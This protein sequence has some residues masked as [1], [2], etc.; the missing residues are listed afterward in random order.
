MRLLSPCFPRR[1]VLDATPQLDAR[2][3]QPLQCSL[4]RLHADDVQQQIGREVA[5]RD[6]HVLRQLVHHHHAATGGVHSRVRITVRLDAVRRAVHRAEEAVAYVNPGVRLQPALLDGVEDAEQDGDLDGARRVE[7]A[8]TVQPPRCACSKSCSATAMALL[9]A[10]SP[11][12]RIVSRSVA[13]CM[14]FP[15]VC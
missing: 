3:V 7:P 11:I 15:E 1:L 2:E 9:P 8:F 4:D 13:S 5:A 6:D 12:C 10:S 14:L